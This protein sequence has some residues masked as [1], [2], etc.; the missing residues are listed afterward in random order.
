[1]TADRVSDSKAGVFWMS[2]KFLK[3]ILKVKLKEIHLSGPLFNR[4]EIS[5]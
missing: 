2:L 5:L 1:M 4:M 3:Q